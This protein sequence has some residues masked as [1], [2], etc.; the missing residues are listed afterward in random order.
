MPIACAV[1]CSKACCQQ[2]CVAALQGGRGGRVVL[3]QWAMLRTLPKSGPLATPSLSAVQAAAAELEAAGHAV[4]R[5][6]RR[7]AAAEEAAVTQRPENADA[8]ECAVSSTLLNCVFLCKADPRPNHSTLLLLLLVEPYSVLL[9]LGPRRLASSCCSHQAGY[10]TSSGPGLRVG[11]AQMA[12]HTQNPR[13]PCN[14]V[15]GLTR[16]RLCVPAAAAR[17][18]RRGAGGGGRAAGDGGLAAAARQQCGRRGRRGREGAGPRTGR[19][20]RR[21][22]GGCWVCSG[23]AAC[24]VRPPPSWPAAPPGSGVKAARAA[25]MET[26]Q[27]PRHHIYAP[28]AAVPGCML[29]A[30]QCA[31]HPTSAAVP[32]SAQHPPSSLKTDADALYISQI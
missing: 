22:R 12:E 25:S 16:R 26:C 4:S 28:S 21:Q 31:H 30:D 5:A 32:S 23:A 8:T 1:S 10:K 13:E 27:Q 19:A 17:H 7:A 29:C 24:I 20:A 18:R 15:S 6:Q 2:I 3:Y 9:T 14:A 11:Q